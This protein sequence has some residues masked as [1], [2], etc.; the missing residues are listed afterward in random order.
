M[1]ISSMVKYVQESFDFALKMTGAITLIYIAFGIN[2]FGSIPF[3]VVVFFI[4]GIIISVFSDN[5]DRMKDLF[6]RNR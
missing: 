5:F 3:W 6:Y 1:T 2:G 4:V